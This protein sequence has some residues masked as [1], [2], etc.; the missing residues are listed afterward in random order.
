ML[1]LLAGLETRTFPGRW[2][3]VCGV[4]FVSVRFF[5]RG[6]IAEGTAGG[7]RVFGWIYPLTTTIGFSLATFF[8]R[9]IRLHT[10]MTSST[11]L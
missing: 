3:L 2:G 11:S 8:D 7:L 5:G 1:L 4:V 6:K 10:S 9:P